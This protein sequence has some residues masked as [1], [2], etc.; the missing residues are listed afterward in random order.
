MMKPV[1]AGSLRGGM[2]YSK[3]EQA[4]GILNPHLGAQHFQLTRYRPSPDL[5]FFIE[6]YWII[7][8]DLRGQAP[9]LSQT[10]PYP[11]VN[12]V[13]EAG[14]SA[15]FGVATGKFDRLLEGT[16]KVFGIKFRPGGFYPFIQSPVAA[17]TNASITLDSVFGPAGG[18]LENCVLSQ[19]DHDQMIVTAEGFL[20]QHRPPC[21]PQVTL[22]N[23]LL[24]C[25]SEN[26][27]INRVADLLAHTSS[28]KRSLQRLFQVYV[29]VSPKWVIKRYR[30]HEAADQLADGIIPD[31]ARLAVSLG[32]FDQAHFIKDFKTIVGQTPLEY[33]RTVSAC[34][35]AEATP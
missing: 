26:P 35:P 34:M 18:K 33:A 14:Q 19:P 29:G 21:D 31:W 22:I 12:L 11:C 8:W 5:R 13:L 32:Y 15:I 7:H 9:Y 2:T 3:I 6:R 23:Q 16:G 30:L 17:F 1:L 20:R 4:K 25:I 27:A 10:L 24:D 28:S